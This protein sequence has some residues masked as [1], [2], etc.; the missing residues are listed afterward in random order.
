M[1]LAFV[2]VSGAAI[3]V[4][5]QAPADFPMK[6]IEV[7]VPY[8]AGG[9]VANMARAFAADA[10]QELGQSLVVVNKEG[11]GGVVGFN[12]LAKSK[13]DGYTIAFS[14]A[15]PMTNAPFINSSMPYRNEQF[16]PVCQI[17]E[18]VFAIAVKPES[19]TRTFADL[20]ERA[21]SSP[22]SVSYGHAGP[23]SVGHLSMAAIER[24]AKIKFN[25]IAYRGDSQAMSDTLAG[26]VDFAAL[27]VGTL[28]GKNLRVLVVLSQKRHPSLPDV[29]SVT[30]LGYP[31]NSQGLNGIF[32]PSGTPRPIIDR[33]AAVCR[34]ISSSAAFVEKARSMSQV[35]NYLGAPEFKAVIDSTFKT[36]E[37]LVP[38]LNLE[39]N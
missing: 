33:Y 8:A 20:L 15:S 27:G 24:A 39:K 28:S 5:A 4:H 37:S 3:T 36:H 34:K 22:E 1:A 38:A 9:G 14:P 26:T 13:P 6:P 10:S 2:A 19:P 30:E 23:A 12:A 16:E 35:V 21:K 17:F 31:A 11:G 18:N 29:P 7:I 25:A 32:V